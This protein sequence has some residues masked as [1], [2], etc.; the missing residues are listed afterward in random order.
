MFNP[1]E[2]H[3]Q[4]RNQPQ[5]LLGNMMGGHNIN[6]GGGGGGAP[7]PPGRVHP[8]PPNPMMGRPSPLE[9]PPEKRMRR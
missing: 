6:V 8:P 3:M 2:R 5:N 4:N 7:P 9:L 1:L